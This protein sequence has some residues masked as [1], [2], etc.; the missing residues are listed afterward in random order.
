[1]A[2]PSYTAIVLAGGRSE[3][4]DGADKAM[5]AI[6]GVTLLDRVLEAASDA[7]HLIVVG[8]RRPTAVPVT[9]WVEE[10]PIGGG[11]A[12]AFAAGVA[13]APPTEALVLLAVDLPFIGAAIPRLLAA[14]QPGIDLTLLE[15]DTGRANYLASAWRRETAVKRLARLPALTGYSMRS[16]LEGLTAAY[17]RDT[18]GWGFDCDTWEA[19]EQAR[20]GATTTA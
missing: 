18:D 4:L 15:D 11:P 9:T 2:P 12:A 5:V 14:L 3:R 7:D 19:V 20:G 6:D 16:L 8:P 17:V 13:A 10:D 1:M